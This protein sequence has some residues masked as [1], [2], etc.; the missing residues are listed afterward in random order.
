M[1]TVCTDRATAASATCGAPGDHFELRFDSLLAD[2]SRFPVT[3][4]DRS[5]SIDSA[6]GHAAAISTPAA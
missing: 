4:P 3:A 1:N 2:G 5:T 6:K